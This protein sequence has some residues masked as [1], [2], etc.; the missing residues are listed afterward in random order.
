MQIDGRQQVPRLS[1]INNGTFTITCAAQISHQVCSLGRGAASRPRSAQSSV[2][3]FE[4]AS[5]EIYN[6][7]MLQDDPIGFL[8]RGQGHRVARGPQTQPVGQ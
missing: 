7:R 8:E 2:F 4:R 1:V 6:S 5:V 3:P